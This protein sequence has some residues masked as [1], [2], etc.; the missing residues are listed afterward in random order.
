MI[1]H[2]C[3]RCGKPESSINSMCDDPN[4]H[5]APCEFVPCQTMFVWKSRSG[6]RPDSEACPPVFLTHRQRNEANEIWHTE[7]GKA[8]FISFN[9]NTDLRDRR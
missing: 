4:Y 9:G 3:K 6:A 1:T 8:W 5:L 2:C 7:D